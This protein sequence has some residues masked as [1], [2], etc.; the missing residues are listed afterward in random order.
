MINALSEEDLTARY[1]GRTVLVTGAN[2]FVGGYLVPRLVGLGAAVYGIGRREHPQVGGYF[3][4]RC[5][6][7]ELESVKQCI[8]RVKPDFVFHLASQSS[9]GTSWSQEWETVETNVKITY[10]LF[11]ALECAGRPVRV[12]LVSSGEVYG[13]LD[14]RKAVES[15]PFRPMNPYAVS[16]AMME[17]MAHRFQN[18]NVDYVVARAFNHTGPGRPGHFFESSVVKQFLMAV[19]EGKKRVQLRVGN[20]DVVRD[21]SDVRDVVEKYLLL[22]LQ[23]KSY[24]AYNVCSGVGVS[25][26]ETIRMIGEITQIHADIEVEEGKLRKNDICILVGISQFSNQVNS[27]PFKTTLMDLVKYFSDKI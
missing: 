3:Y 5:D 13:D 18:T 15:D 20:I 27:I 25:L 17:I 1:A 21:Y 11:K 2:G 22:A 26:R 14:G 7:N 8:G 4:H 9:V 24:E 23:G 19:K 6:L 10:H 12:L 16:K